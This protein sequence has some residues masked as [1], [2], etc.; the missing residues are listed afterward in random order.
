MKCFSGTFRW[1]QTSISEEG[2]RTFF[3]LYSHK[4]FRFFLCCPLL[5]CL[6]CPFRLANCDTQRD[7]V[8][9]F[10]WRILRIRKLEGG[11]KYFF[12][13]VGNCFS[14]EKSHWFV[15]FSR[16]ECFFLSL[17][18]MNDAMKWKNIFQVERRTIWEDFTTLN[19]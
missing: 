12:L 19:I 13:Y 15:S 14:F 8:A 7:A 16:G 5:L 6:S 4:S 3:Y 18:W 9:I 10:G 2:Y 17:I 1:A 11:K